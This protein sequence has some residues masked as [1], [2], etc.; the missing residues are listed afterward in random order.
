MRIATSPTPK[1]VKAA[2]VACDRAVTSLHQH[3]ILR[4]GAR[5]HGSGVPEQPIGLDEARRGACNRAATA[6]ADDLSATHGLGIE[7]AFVY[8]GDKVWIDLAVVALV[9]RDGRMVITTSLGIPGTIA[10]VGLS[11]AAEQDK[12]AGSFIAARTGCDGADWHEMVTGGHMGREAI[13][14]D[15]IYAALVIAAQ[16]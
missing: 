3:F 13:L 11:I 5:K 1:K 15:A 14:S 7:N 4:Q 2:Q 6:L 12:T 9:N 16:G 10:D 8:L